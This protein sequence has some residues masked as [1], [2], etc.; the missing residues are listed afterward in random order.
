MSKKKSQSPV[1]VVISSDHHTGSTVGVCPPEGVRLDDA[2][3]YLPSLPQQWLWQCWED[4]NNW[5][6]ALKREAKAEVW[7]VYNGDMVDG[8]HHHTH[9]IISRN[10]DAQKYVAKRVFSRPNAILKPTRLFVVRGTEVHVGSGGSSE[11]SL[12]SELNAER[13]AE[14]DTWSRWRLRLEVHGKL[15]DF[16]HHG[17]IGSQP[18]TK[19]NVINANAAKIFYEHVSRN[20]RYPDIAVRS[21]MH[22]WG[23]SFEAQPVRLLQTP[24]WQLKTGFVHR[25]APENIADIGGCAILVQPD[26]SY[27]VKKKLYTPALPE[28]VK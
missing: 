7:K 18:W 14:T 9:Q 8:D 27:E 20:L 17:K 10:A 2:G 5:A 28:I 26:G 1:L 23:D 3:R 11:E 16:Q 6:A 4:F 15:I 24:S 13:D 21:H 22:Q 25:V 19:Q 12:A